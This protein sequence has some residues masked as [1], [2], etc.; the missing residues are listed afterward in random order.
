[1][2]IYRILGAV[3]LAFSGG[4]G[5]YLSNQRAARVLRQTEAWLAL[6]H[7]I[8][9]QVDCFARPISDILSGCE[10]SLLNACGYRGED[11][12]ESLDALLARCAIGDGETE[13]IVTDFS[14]EFGKSY[15]EEQI[16]SCSYSCDRL[17]R[18]RDALAEQLPAK[19]RVNSALWISGAL[20][21][22]ILLI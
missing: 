12:P 20:T 16:K 7:H 8:R 14:R 17:I 21:V 13:K 9:G 4:L 3:L 11:V 18:R 6:L 2:G 10:L 5:A 15:R 1:M 22:V 19:R